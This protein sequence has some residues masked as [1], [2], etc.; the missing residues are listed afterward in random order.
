MSPV[1]GSKWSSFFAIQFGRKSHPAAWSDINV[2]EQLF[3]DA[4]K[5]VLYSGTPIEVEVAYIS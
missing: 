4:V 1:G 2:N 5:A 3:K